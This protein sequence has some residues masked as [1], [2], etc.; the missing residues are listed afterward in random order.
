MKPILRVFRRPLVIGICVLVLVV[1]TISYFGRHWFNVQSPM[2]VNSAEP[3]AD[4]NRSNNGFSERESDLVEA[5][6][7]PVPPPRE[8][9]F[10]LGAYPTLPADWPRQDVWEV[11]EQDYKAGKAQI[12]HELVQ[13]VLV[14]FW[15]QGK[16]ADF[17]FMRDG[18]V[19]PVFRDTIYI[20]WTETEHD[21]GTTFRY[22]SEITCPQSLAHYDQEDIV[23]GRVPSDIKVIDQNEGGIDP[24]SFLGLP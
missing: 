21:D 17:A 16:P 3:A 4:S 24:Y 22:I 19:Y 18:K 5:G 6:K 2:P 13:R 23:Q 10:G 11:L 12:G 7:L 1:V 8:S 15:K 14:K 20:R 9:P